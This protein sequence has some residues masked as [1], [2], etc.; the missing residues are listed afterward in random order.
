MLNFTVDDLLQTNESIVNQTIPTFHILVMGGFFM[1]ISVK[2]G[3]GFAEAKRECCQ[4][5]AMKIRSGRDSDDRHLRKS[6]HRRTG[7]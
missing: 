3:K 1:R 6:V 5:I 7:A 2:K 4:W